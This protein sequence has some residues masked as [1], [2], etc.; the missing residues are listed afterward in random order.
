MTQRGLLA[1]YF[2]YRLMSLSASLRFKT[3]ISAFI[4]FLGLNFLLRKTVIGSLL[5]EFWDHYQFTNDYFQSLYFDSWDSN[6]IS[7]MATREKTFMVDIKRIDDACK[8][9]QRTNCERDW[10][11]L[12]MEKIP[13]DFTKAHLGRRRSL[14][15][16]MWEHQKQAI[17]RAPN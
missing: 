15:P 8:C 3:S 1:D 6:H 12:V 4:N 10:W 14:S 5:T 16:R 9:F 17:K 13:K 2:V 7:E 11:W